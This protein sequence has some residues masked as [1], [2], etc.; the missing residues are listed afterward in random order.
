MSNFDDE[1]PDNELKKTFKAPQPRL[2]DFLKAFPELSMPVVL[3]EDTHHAFSKNNK[4]IPN[5]LVAHFLAPLQPEDADEFT[6][7]IPC[8]KIAGTE[9]FEAIVY[10]KAE[11]L[12][13]QYI[14]LTFTNK[15]E[16]IDQKV[17]A[18]TTVEHNTLTTSVANID[19][20]LIITVVSGQSATEEGY[21]GNTSRSI[22]LEILPN[23][24]IISEE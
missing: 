18:G 19:E 1:T 11:L 10:W 4:P 17:I 13:Y 2:S 6:E 9:N 12:N 16:L 7:Y 8:F 5:H 24:A 20:D 21:D 15:G 3:G 22:S 23:G 14:L